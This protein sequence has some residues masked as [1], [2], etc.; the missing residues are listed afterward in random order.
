VRWHTIFELLAYT[1]GFQLFLYLRRRHAHPTTGRI[2]GVWVLVG[3]I[4]EIGRAH[5]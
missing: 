2:E 3:A 4:L 5:V 1:G